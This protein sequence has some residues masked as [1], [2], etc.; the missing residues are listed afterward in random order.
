MGGLNRKWGGE[1]CTV[2]ILPAQSHDTLKDELH[3]FPLVWPQPACEN[4]VYIYG[5]SFHAHRRCPQHQGLAGWGPAVLQV[6]G[7]RHQ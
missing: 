4:W 3:A 5:R 7:D 1:E 6:A 2:A